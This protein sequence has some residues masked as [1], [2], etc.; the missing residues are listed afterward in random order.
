LLRANLRD[1]RTLCF[2]L[3]DEAGATEWATHQADPGFQAVVTGLSVAWDREL[4]T[5][6]LPRAFKKT[7]YTAELI[8][9]KAGTANGIRIAVLADDAHA[10]LTLYFTGSPKV[11]RYDLRRVG[12]PRFLVPDRAQAR[13]EE[14]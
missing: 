5:L 2:D 11:T 7:S 8:R 12:K 13:N 1:G 4:Y 3:L 10:S 14:D 9:D 6:P